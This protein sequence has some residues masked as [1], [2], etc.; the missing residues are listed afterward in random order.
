MV[1]FDNQ[2]LFEGRGQLI[3]YHFIFDPAWEQG[4]PS[5]SLLV[6]NIGHLAHLHARDTSLALVSRAPLATI[7]PFR[8]RMDWTVPWYSTFGSDFNYDFH[9]TLDQ[10]LAPVEYNYTALSALGPQWQD[11]SG[12]MHGIS[13]FLRH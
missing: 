12:E 11:W 4:C 3:I 10:A 8:Q 7:E 5:C 6:D 13:A 2:Y 1:E 9:V